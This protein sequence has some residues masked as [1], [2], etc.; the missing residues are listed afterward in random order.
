MFK[1]KLLL[2]SFFLLSFFSVNLFSQD[3]FQPPKPLEIKVYDAMVGEWEGVSDMMGMKSNDKLKIYWTL[4]KQF[5]VM[6]MKSVGV[7]NP[8]NVFNAICYYSVDK[9]GKSVSWWFDDWGTEMAMSGTGVISDNK[10]TILSSNSMMKDDRTVEVNGSEMT[11]SGVTTWT[12]GGQEMKAE[13]KTVF[14][15]K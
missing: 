13:S 12:Q 2:I 3:Q 15:K 9:D 14:N 7:D 5:L 1:A 8:K 10:F 4:N 6:E 11:V